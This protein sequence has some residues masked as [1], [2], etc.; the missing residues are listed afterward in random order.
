[1]ATIRLKGQITED[2]RLEVELPDGLESG[3]VNVVIETTPS[4]SSTGPA[5]TDEE[6]EEL[7]RIEP[8]SGADIVASLGTGW[9]SLTVSGSDWVEQIRRR[10]REQSPV[11]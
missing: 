3:E 2:G 6:I 11:P 7:T 8:K 5:W 9:E 1:M 10:R 4:S